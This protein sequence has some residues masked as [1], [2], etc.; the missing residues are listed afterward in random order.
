MQVIKEKEG[1]LVTLRAGCTGGARP[2]FLREKKHPEQTV[3]E[4][5]CVV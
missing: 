3:W 4:L 1:R 5:R 2:A